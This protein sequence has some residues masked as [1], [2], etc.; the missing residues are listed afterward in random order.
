MEGG[1]RTYVEYYNKFRP[2]MDLHGFTPYEKFKG[3]LRGKT[4]KDFEVSSNLPL[5]RILN[6]DT[7]EN[8]GGVI[9][10]EKVI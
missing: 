2:H 3:L 5:D 8:V 10:D 9:K 6:F 1:L 4:P 7:N